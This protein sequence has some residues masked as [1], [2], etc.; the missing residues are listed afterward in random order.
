MLSIMRRVNFVV[1]NATILQKKKIYSKSVTTQ[2]NLH[3]ESHRKISFYLQNFHNKSTKIKW[4]KKDPNL[5]STFSR[6]V[7]TF[8]VPT[9]SEKKEIIF[10]HSPGT[11]SSICN[12]IFE[13]KSLRIYTYYAIPVLK[14]GCCILGTN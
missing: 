13:S 1:H 9:S 3:K 5:L 7:C 10:L 14:N 12:K 8:I 2:C 11:E 4:R 6:Q